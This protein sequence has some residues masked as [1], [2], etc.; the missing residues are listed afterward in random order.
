M[1]G[2]SL[3]SQLTSQLSRFDTL[4]TQ[5]DDLQRS[6]SSNKKTT[7][8]QGLGDD[9]LSSLQY[10]TNLRSGEKYVSNIDIAVVRINTVNNSISLIQKQVSQLQTGLLQQP[11]DGE[12]DISKIQAYADKLVEI[13]P[14]NLNENVDGRFVFS[15][16][17]V[18]SKPYEGN[19]KLAAAVDADV[20]DWLD[21]TITTDTFLTRINNYTND[22]VGF[23]PEVLAAGNVQVTA[24]ENYKLD[25]TFKA[26]DPSIKDI[27]VVAQ[28][29][30]SLTAPSETDVPNVD[31]LNAIVEAMALKLNGGAEGL[32]NQIVKLQAGLATLND[33]RESH[34]FDKNTLEGLIE[35][36]ENV[37]ISETAVKLQNVQLQLEASYRVTSVTA[38]LNLLNFLN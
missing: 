22:Q 26:S 12:L 18:D 10:R 19:A 2:V 14:A 17:D 35:S 34:T 4:N 30:K 20:S 36:I 7:S 1:S 31:N 25:Y 8:Y 9:A 23:T 38:G 27:T 11:L 3:L 32:E 37:D 16:A 13:L 28:V 15:G 21:G 5:F 29:L 24:D 6:L 33:I